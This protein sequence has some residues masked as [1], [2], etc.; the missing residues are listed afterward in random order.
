[1]WGDVEVRKKEAVFP[2]WV[3]LRA[4]KVYQLSVRTRVCWECA[5]RSP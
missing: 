1:M 3:R 4:E 5:Y 2:D